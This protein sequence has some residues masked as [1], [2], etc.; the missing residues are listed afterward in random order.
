MGKDRVKNARYFYIAML[1][2]MEEARG[3]GLAS[4][5]VR[6]VKEQAR[7]AGE[8]VWLETSTDNAKRMYERCGFREVD[9]ARLGV[10]DVNEDGWSTAKGREGEGTEPKG[11]RCWA[12]AWWPEWETDE[13]KGA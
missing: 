3:K 12:M 8:P 13:G 9:M 10:G 4:A 1:G 2:T 6:L 7:K 11:V 5:F